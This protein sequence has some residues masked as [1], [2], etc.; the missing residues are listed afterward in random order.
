VGETIKLLLGTSESKNAHALQVYDDGGQVV[1]RVGFGDGVASIGVGKNGKALAKMYTIGDQGSVSVLQDNVA[2]ASINNADSPGA[3]IVVVRN[4]AGNA[5]AT[6]G[7]SSTGDGGNITVRDPGGDG[8]FSAGYASDGGGEA[9]LNRVNGAG[10]W[11][12]SCLGVG[13]PGMGRGK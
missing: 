7:L 13:L 8:V 9:C 4:N 10:Q 6:L 1:A 3:G 5:V 11:D 12:L 2:V